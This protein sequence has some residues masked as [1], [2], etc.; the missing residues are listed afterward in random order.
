VYWFFARVVNRK[1]CTFR[2][3]GFKK[4]L[5]RAGGFKFVMWSVW[6]GGFELEKGT[7]PLDCLL[8]VNI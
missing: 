1:F 2:N 4:W 3:V 5:D 7:R 8:T 6:I